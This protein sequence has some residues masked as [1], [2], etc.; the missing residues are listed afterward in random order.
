VSLH[1]RQSVVL[2][3]LSA[4]LVVAG[5]TPA[6][7]AA[8]DPA[9]S[10]F[11]VS[12]T[13]FAADFAPLP[14]HAALSAILSRPARVTVSIRR[15]NAT[16]VRRLARNVRKNAGTRSWT[17]DGHNDAGAL[18]RDHDDDLARN[19]VANEARADIAVHVHNNSLSDKSANG[20][21]TYTDADRTWTPEGV[22]LSTDVLRCV[23]ATLTSYTSSTFQPRDA[24]VHEAWYYYMGPYDPPYLP[25]AALM[26]S[27]LSESL[28]ISDASELEALKRPEV[29][30]S[31]AAGIYLGVAQYLNERAYGIAYELV[32]G[33]SSAVAAST[34]SYD[35]RI[36]NRGN[37]TSNDWA[38]TLSSVPSVPLYDGSGAHGTQMGRASI[39]DGLA[40]GRSAVVRVNTTLPADAGDWLVK[41]DVVLPGGEHLADAGIVPLQLPLTTTIAP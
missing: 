24:G 2:A 3:A 26:T 27:V 38:L 21:Q 7:V 9:L 20:T 34:Q 31:I 14:T 10:S 12:G 6:R 30:L 39:P 41:S 36:T 8:A 16:L 32:S 5:L 13:P 19:D 18:V 25:R 40:P 33:P 28:Y 1:S 29:R 22:D 15:P 17:W 11:S 4:V 35:V 37:A 23:V